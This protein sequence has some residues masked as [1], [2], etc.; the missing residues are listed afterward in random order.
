[1]AIHLVTVVGNH[2][3]VF[4][5]MLSH[6][7]S[8]GLSS[9]VVNIHLDSYQ[10]PLYETILAIARRHRAEVNAVLVGKW[11]QAVN[12][13]LYR[14]TMEQAPQDWFVL[15]D[16][17]E[18]QVYPDDLETVICRAERQ[19]SD[20]IE[21]YVVDR[22]SQDGVLREADLHSPL[23]AQFP[24]AGL[25]TFPLLG[26][27]ILKVVAAKGFVRLAPG[28]HYAYEGRPCSRKSYYIPV[29]HFKWTAG[30]MERLRER[31]ILYKSIGDPLWQ[32]SDCFLRYFAENQGHIQIQDPRFNLQESGLIC[33]HESDLRAIVLASAARMPRPGPDV[34]RRSFARFLHAVLW[35]KLPGNARART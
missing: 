32:E 31:T 28:Q 12:P 13:F 35:N 11:L 30:L 18:L 19:G 6:Y 3:S 21:G 9:L 17:D 23:W 2:T 20:F 1:M 4:D 33:P 15:S 26:G 5:Q 34:A 7:R 14:H 10:N 22:V 27:N 25:I 24:M 16:T 29:H 8:I